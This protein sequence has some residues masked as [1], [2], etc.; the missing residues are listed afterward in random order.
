MRLRKGGPGV[1]LSNGGNSEVSFP[2]KDHLTIGLGH[3]D[4]DLSLRC[5]GLRRLGVRCE[6]TWVP[7]PGTQRTLG[8]GCP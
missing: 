1:R 5:G 4:Q 2:Q 3:R 8:C 7:E 6:G